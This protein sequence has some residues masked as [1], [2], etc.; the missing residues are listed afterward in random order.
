MFKNPIVKQVVITV[1]VII[2]FNYIVKEY[3]K[4]K[5]AQNAASIASVLDLPTV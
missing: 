3:K 5:V 2:A 1:A 4:A